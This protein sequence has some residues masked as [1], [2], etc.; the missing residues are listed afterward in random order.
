MFWRFS[1]HAP[2][3]F[4]SSYSSR[5]RSA[6]PLATERTQEWRGGVDDEHII[7]GQAVEVIDE[8][9]DFLINSFFNRHKL[10]CSVTPTNRMS[11]AS[12]Q[13]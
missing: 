4:S 12:S 6:L 8:A 13:M 2:S 9:V 1:I 5:V 10:L 11:S 7:V 3:F